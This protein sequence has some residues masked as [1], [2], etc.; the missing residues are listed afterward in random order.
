MRAGYEGYGRL[1]GRIGETAHRSCVLLTSRE[2]LADLIP[3][4]GSYP[5][6]R[7]FRIARLEGDACEQLWAE[8]GVE[9]PAPERAQLI[10]GYA[11]NPLALKIVAQT[12]IDLFGGD[13]ASFLE[14]GAIIYSSI[15]DLLAEQFD[16]LSTVERSIIY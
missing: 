10:E 7:V 12:I 2:K 5:P 4:E 1:L 8:K 6:V 14:Q 9:G 3:L 16:R 15:R 13:V 11:G